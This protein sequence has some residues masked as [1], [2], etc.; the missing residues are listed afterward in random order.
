MCNEKG[1]V[2]NSDEIEVKEF[3]GKT[4]SL[5]KILICHGSLLTYS[6]EIIPS[7]LRKL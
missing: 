4:G 6:K 5:L 1:G 2:W 3:L 7:I